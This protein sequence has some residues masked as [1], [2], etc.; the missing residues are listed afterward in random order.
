MC[1]YLCIYIYAYMYICIYI[2]VFIYIYMCFLILLYIYVYLITCGHTYPHTHTHT[3]ANAL[4]HSHITRVVCDGKHCAMQS[5]YSRTPSR[6]HQHPW[7]L[8]PVHI[9]IHMYTCMCVCVHIKVYTIHILPSGA[10][11]ALGALLWYI[12]IYVYA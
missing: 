1:F 4:T 3:H 6:S 11:G 7:F 12:Y 9:C 8:T 10:F 5:V 2:Y